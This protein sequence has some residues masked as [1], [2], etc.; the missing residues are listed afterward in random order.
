MEALSRRILRRNSLVKE[1]AITRISTPSLSLS[2]NPK[3]CGAAQ[4]QLNERNSRMRKRIMHPLVSVLVSFMM[5]LAFCPT[6]SGFGGKPTIVFI[7]IDETELIPSAENPCGFDIIGRF[8]G[9]VKLTLNSS[10]PNQVL[11]AEGDHIH[12]VFSNPENGN[13]VSFV[14]AE[15][16]TAVPSSDGTSVILTI[17]GLQG[18][19]TLPHQGLVT[20]DVGRLILEFPCLDLQCPPDIIFAAGR[21]D[22]GPFPAL[23]DL[24]SD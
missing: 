12:G 24:L 4:L 9:R 10:N 20:A 22:F 2:N 8:E 11:F 18:R 5:L 7:P 3:R 1:R 21:I 13:S 14:E 19:I 17:N 16:I 15:Y 6:R 23:C